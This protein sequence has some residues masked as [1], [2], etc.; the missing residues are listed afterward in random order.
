[1]NGNMQKKAIIPDS[2]QI[3]PM[4]HHKKMV[5]L[6]NFVKNPRI[7]A[8]DY[9]YYDDLEA[10]ENFEKN[11]LY[12]FDFIGDKLIIGKFCA[13]ASGVKF[14]MNGAN[15]RM[16]GFSTYPFEIFGG[17]W[18]EEVPARDEFPYK[19]DTIL[20]NDVWVGYNSMI[21]PG[22]TIGNG[23]IVAA[24]SVVT[25]DAPDYSIVGG[26]PARVIR[27]RFD[28]KVIRKLLETAWWDWD[29]E[30]ITK[31]KAIIESADIES[32]EQIK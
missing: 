32:L 10:P 12:H 4:E 20:K 13:I 16:K 30:K 3:Y 28:E 23:A 27:L 1:M 26:N 17:G 31:H 22:V 11:V 2:N 6:K 5:F 21:M 8:G 19:G 24:G 25:K 7:V 15:H 9:S 29:I 14:I 18:A